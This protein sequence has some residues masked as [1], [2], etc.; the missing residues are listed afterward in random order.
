MQQTVF[1]YQR[2]QFTFSNKN[3]SKTSETLFKLLKCIKKYL[4]SFSIFFNRLIT[5]T[6]K[7]TQSA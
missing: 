5:E 7:N 2:I 1:Q 3:S 4:F 6:V